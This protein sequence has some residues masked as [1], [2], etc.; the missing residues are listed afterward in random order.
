MLLLKSALDQ[1]PDGV[2]VFDADSLRVQFVNEEASRQSGYARDELLAMHAYDITPDISKARFRELAAPLLSGEQAAINFET[3]QA[4]KSGQRSPVD[5]MLRGIGSTEGPAQLVAILRDATERKQTEAALRVAAA[6]FDSQECTIITDAAGVIVRV[7][8]AFTK[9]TGYTAEEAVGQTPRLLKSDRHEDGF[10]HAI[11]DALI[12][13]GS[14]QGEI[15]NRRKTAEVRPA[16]LSVSAVKDGE[17]LVTHYVGTLV[18]VS[19]R[20]AAEDR[21]RE[22]AFYDPL[23]RLPNR[24]LL[25]DRLDRSLAA[26]LRGRHRGALLLL[27]LDDF[28]RLNDTQ[29]HGVGDRLI[30][31][32]ARRLQASVRKADT[33]ARLGGDEFVVILENL[34]TEDLAAARAETVAEKITALFER[35]FRL[36]IDEGSQQSLEFHCTASL[37]ITLFGSLTTS[38]DELMRQADLAMYQA[39]NA[40]RN[41]IRF[42]DPAMQ[43]AVKAR[44]SLEADLRQAVQKNQFVLHYQP[45]VDSDGRLIGAEALVRWQH[46]RLGMVSPSDFIPL[47]EETGL[48]LPLGNWVLETA[49]AQLVAWASHHETAKLTLAVNVSGHQFHRT[50]FVEHVLTVLESSGADP[51]KLKLELTESLLLKDVEDI[52][53]KMSSL[54]AE[55]VGFSLDD[56]G[57]GYSSLSYLKRLPLDQLKI[58]QGFVRDI[59][60]NANDAAIAKMVVTLAENMGLEVIAEGVEEEAQRGFLANHGC[61]R[62]QGYLFSRPLPVETFEEFIRQGAACAPTLASASLAE[63]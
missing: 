42:F 50:D 52:I 58:D 31:E 29:G 27:D 17:G 6:A 24:L 40:G 12:H 26:A 30:L 25:L 54:K 36:E 62:Y 16:W 4:R 28:K 45:Q 15:W 41:C 2:F 20:K 3:L 14:W 11:K 59:L 39:K 13:N 32:V 1:T 63:A 57:T 23:T 47:A 37:G 5:V 48:I 21:L 61:H 43:A 60:V 44:V 18:D 46:P 33:L 51:R 38:T 10:Y 49:C 55:G 8:P 9:T 35:P 56:F 53:A 34:G 19:E 22:L 7:N